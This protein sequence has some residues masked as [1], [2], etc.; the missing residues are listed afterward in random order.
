M[1][2]F[3]LKFEWSIHHVTHM[4]DTHM[5][6]THMNVTHMNVTHMNVTHINEACHSYVGF[7]SHVE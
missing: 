1:F 7:T 4:N 2:V 6:V 3:L 5:N